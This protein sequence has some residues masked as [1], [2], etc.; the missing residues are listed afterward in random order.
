MPAWPPIKVANGCD[1]VKQPCHFPFHLRQPGLAGIAHPIPPTASAI[2]SALDDDQ[3]P[4]LNNHSIL[5][6]PFNTLPGMDAPRLQARA[7][8]LWVW[9]PTLTPGLNAE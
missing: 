1:S 5:A 6:L 9:L 7:A 2:T 8:A 3:Y 4:L